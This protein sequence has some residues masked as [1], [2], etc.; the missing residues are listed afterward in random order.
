MKIIKVVLIIILILVSVRIGSLLWSI[1]DYSQVQEIEYPKKVYTEGIDYSFKEE[2][3]KVIE[4]DSFWEAL[5]RVQGP[6][7][8]GLTIE[9][10]EFQIELIKVEV[11]RLLN[12]VNKLDLRSN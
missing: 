6:V 9:E 4:V 8:E 10:I 7:A 3:I 12:E 1:Y 2:E 5:D 11:A